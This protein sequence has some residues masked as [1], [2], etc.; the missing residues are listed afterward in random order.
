M[1]GPQGVFGSP[2]FQ[3]QRRPAE[4]PS[5]DPVVNQA[6]TTFREEFSED[7][8]QDDLENI[9]ELWETLTP[10]QA[11][12]AFAE[13]TPQEISDWGSEAQRSTRW[14]DNGLTGGQQQDLFDVL[15]SRLEGDQLYQVAVAFDNHGRM[16]SAVAE[17]A[18]GEVRAA[19]LVASVPDA[20]DP[21]A[22]A[23]ALMREE[24]S[25][26]VDQDDLELISRLWSILPAE[27][28]QRAFDMLSEE[29]VAFW[30]SEAQR[31]TNTTDNGLTGGQTQALFDDLAGKLSGEQLARLGE[32]FGNHPRMVDALLANATAGARADYVLA[33]SGDISSASNYRDADILRAKSTVTY[34][35]D[36]AHAAVDLL[37]SLESEPDQFNRVLEGLATDDKLDEVLEIARGQVDTHSH[38]DVSSDY[39]TSALTTIIDAAARHGSPEVR[40]EVFEAGA[41]VL[42]L[43]SGNTPGDAV[44]DG[45]DE[46]TADLLESLHGLLS[47]DPNGTLALLESRYRDGDG[48]TSFMRE[49]I[50]HGRYEDVA[51]L[52]VQVQRGDSGDADPADHFTATDE[53]GAYRNAQVLGYTVGSLQSGITELNI[54]AAEQAEHLKGIFEPIALLGEATGTVGD[55]TTSGLEWVVGQKVDAATDELAAERIDL[56]GAIRELAY[57]QETTGGETLPV[58]FEPAET[59]YD[60]AVGR[61]ID[62]QTQE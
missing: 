22:A 29:E 40:A 11:Q 31:S 33:I 51:A 34:G 7:V 12:E 42:D 35:N 6:I 38:G 62:A 2:T 30:G 19:F 44:V 46:A 9:T 49:M 60:A 20:E 28:A 23:V 32:A 24:F 41:R 5:D 27:D 14:T 3:F 54:S 47:D 56:A 39:D 58:E 17:H 61:V 59:A 13:L 57:P 37:V 36:A 52:V 50:A 21:A 53:A 1:S 48:M 18:S 45:S 16:Q 55:V 4:G 15:A 26:D 10:Q 8:D 25:E 43:V